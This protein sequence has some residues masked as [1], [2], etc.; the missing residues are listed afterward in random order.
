MPPH[1]ELQTLPGITFSLLLLGILATLLYL[2][3]KRTPIPP[4]LLALPAL[5]FTPFLHI[6]PAGEAFAPR[7]AH[8]PL[9]FAIPL[10]DHLL[11]R[12]PN[13]LPP[14]LLLTL[15]PLTWATIPTY[16][17]AE[18][19]WQRTL[20][21]TPTSH[22]AWNALG[23]AR[24]D[25]RRHEEA[26]TSFRTALEL[27]PGHSRTWSNLARSLQ[28]IGR[29][30]EAVKALE[31]AVTTGPRNPIAHVNWGRHLAREGRHAEAR[32]AFLRA[33]RLQPGFHHAWTGLAGAEA[34]LGH[35]AAAAAAHEQARSRAP[36]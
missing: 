4:T 18:S 36:R 26:I 25:Q 7:F 27:A 33:T 5:A 19:Y 13:Y 16:A 30:A 34:A 29:E 6:L 1:Y 10:I 22:I 32:E 3:H 12:L 8:L 15:I 35:P 24:A 23:I 17:D 31:T 2:L 20:H 11:R 14:L 28:S 9:L 21:H